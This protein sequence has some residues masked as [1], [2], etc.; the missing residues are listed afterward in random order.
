MA[1]KEFTVWVEGNIGAG[2][3]TLLDYFA[4]QA[5]VVREPVEK[6][7]NVNGHNLLQ[8]L[9]ENPARYAYLFQS[10]VMLTA[11][12]NHLSTSSQPVKIIERSLFSAQYCFAENFYQNGQLHDAEYETLNQWLTLLT[13]SCKL[14]VDLII[15]LRCEPETALER[16]KN[17]ARKEEE[18]LSLSYLQE[19]HM[20]HENWLVHHKFPVPAPV[21]VLDANQDLSAIKK[22]YHQYQSVILGQ[23]FLS[24][25]NVNPAL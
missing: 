11:V 7:Q 25:E 22:V 9:Y 24:G 10:A 23:N 3:S 17:R 14:P 1:E 2:K 21:L 8:L 19:L 4:S 12:Q 5:E 20:S 6:W 16:I 13:T 18:N 15:Y